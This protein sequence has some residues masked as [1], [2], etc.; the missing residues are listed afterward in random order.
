MLCLIF[1]R[2]PPWAWCFHYYFLYPLLYPTPLLPDIT[3]TFG[4]LFQSD[5]NLPCSHPNLI[6][7]FYFINSSSYHW[8]LSCA[9]PFTTQLSTFSPSMLPSCPCFKPTCK[10]MSHIHSI[11]LLLK[12]SW[13]PLLIPCLLLLLPHHEQ[14]V[15]QRAWRSIL[16]KKK[17]LHC[18]PFCPSLNSTRPSEKF[19]KVCAWKVL[20]SARPSHHFSDKLDFRAHQG[21]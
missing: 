1:H 18:P 19:S 9:N 11:P 21:N 2:M 4:C 12:N 10:F 5:L 16:K 13:L 3:D 7:N 20:W 17:T 15:F 14:Q 8:P 6:Y